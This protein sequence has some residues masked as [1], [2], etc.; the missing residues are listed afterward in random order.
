MGSDAWGM[1]KAEVHGMDKELE[2]WK[3]VSESSSGGEQAFE[4]LKK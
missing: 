1:M 4:F 2:K 3:S